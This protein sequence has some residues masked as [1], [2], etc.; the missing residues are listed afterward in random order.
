VD[1]PKK[2]LRANRARYALRQRSAAA[3]TVA[4][5]GDIMFGM[6]H[7]GNSAVAVVLWQHFVKGHGVLL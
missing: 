2:L 5:V 1:A 7:M 6:R 3:A 4:M